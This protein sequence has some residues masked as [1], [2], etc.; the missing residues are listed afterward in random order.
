[1]TTRSNP[2]DGLGSPP[3]RFFSPDILAREAPFVLDFEDLT[4]RTGA[5][6]GF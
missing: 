6:Q 2:L 4:R 1:M 3:R 5:G